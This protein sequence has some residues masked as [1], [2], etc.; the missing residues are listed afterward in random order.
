MFSETFKSTE[1]SVKNV[2][3]GIYSN[4]PEW[5]RQLGEY[6]YDVAAKYQILKDF[7]I[8]FG[9]L[10]AFPLLL[11]F[12]WCVGS[13]VATAII[14]AV[15]YTAINGFLI[16]GAFLVLAPVFIVTVATAAIITCIVTVCRGTLWTGNLVFKSTLNFLRHDNN[17]ITNDGEYDSAEGSTDRR[18]IYIR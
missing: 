5:V 12:G 15:A 9:T 16:G 1:E 6:S 2:S 7:A 17:L 3:T 14:W 4:L 8:A 11:F 10:F 18:A 13:L